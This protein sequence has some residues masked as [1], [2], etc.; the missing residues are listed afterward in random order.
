M[1]A[2]NKIIR[3]HI[4]VSNEQELIKSVLA[5]MLWQDTF[6]RNGTDIATE[7]S[8]LVSKVSPDFTYSLALLARKDWNIRHTPLFLMRCLAANKT[9]KAEWLAEV[10]TRADEISEFLAIYWKDGKCPISNQVKKGLA[11]A[12]NKFSAY[13]LAKYDRNSASIRLRDVLFLV[14][15]KPNDAD[16]EK[17]FA[18]LASNTLVSPDTWEVALSSGQDKRETFERLLAS[19]GLGALAFLRNLRNMHESLVSHELISNYAKTLDVSKV[20]PFRYLAAVRAAPVFSNMLETLM[21]KSQ[22]GAAKLPGKTQ[23]LIDVSGSM[24]WDLGSKS[25]LTRIDAASALAIL[26]KG[27][28]EDLEMYTFSTSLVRVKYPSS[29]F[30]LA[31]E[32]N[33]S[34]P[35]SG[36]YLRSS[37][38]LLESHAPEA[39][40]LIV[41]TDEESS[42]GAA[43]NTRNIPAYVINVAGTTSKGIKS[44]QGFHSITGFSEV[45]VRYIQVLESLNRAEQ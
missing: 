27:I 29:G 42:D 24:D 19:K 13:E 34:Q 31:E 37:L 36:T 22:K 23:L 9:M 2:L 41:I 12:L 35:H 5:C 44:V 20:L 30:T 18:D 40:R 4:R 28:C 21:L 43:I 1:T 39:D 38:E 10:I 15:A 32:I 25:D 45:I 3:T 26:L 16:K 8:T 33:N 11:L 7:I 6:Y 14:H 17:L